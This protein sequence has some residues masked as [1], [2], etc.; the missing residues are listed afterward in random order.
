VSRFLLLLLVLLVP[1]R[2][3]SAETMALRMA[4]NGSP[5]A[6][7]A[8]GDEKPSAHAARCTT[9]VRPIRKAWAATATCASCA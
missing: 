7:M 1:L 8:Q 2:A 9:P 3:L 5:A 4:A 6:V